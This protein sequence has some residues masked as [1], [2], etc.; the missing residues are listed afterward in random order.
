MTLKK[1]RISISFLLLLIIGCAPSRFVKTLDQGEMAVN[2]SLGGPL[3]NLFGATIPIPYTTLG[4]GYGIKDDLTGFGAIHS[5]SL[6]FSTL[7]LDLGVTK[8]WMLPD[9][10]KK[11]IPGI[12][13]T[14]A[15]NSMLDL[16]EGAFD[17]YPEIDVNAY[18]NYSKNKN[19]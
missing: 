18:W 6:V 3:I 8:R 16:K 13:S 9:S 4:M 15:L 11:Y 14:L 10:T 7:Q 2:G 5:T 19:H 1:I 17:L 12:S